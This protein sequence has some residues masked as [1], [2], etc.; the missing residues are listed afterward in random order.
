MF[1]QAGNG[2]GGPL[3]SSNWTKENPVQTSNLTGVIDT[4]VGQYSPSSF[5]LAVRSDGT[6]WSWGIGYYGELGNGSSGSFNYSLVPAAVKSPDGT[7]LLSGVTS[8]SANGT[9]VLALKTDG[10]IWAWGRNN[11][12]QLGDGTFGT[13]RLLPVQVMQGGLPFKSPVVSK[14]GPVDKS[15]AS[16]TETITRFGCSATPARPFD[17]ASDLASIAILLAPMVV[18]WG[19]RRRPQYRRFVKKGEHADAA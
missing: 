9:H 17:G 5:S 16:G 12:G 3:D 1:G 7:G 13:D 19:N 14:S 6:V 4:S 11:F 15:P 2:T 8:I 10:T 18:L